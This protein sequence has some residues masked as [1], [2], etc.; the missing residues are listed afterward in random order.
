MFTDNT[1]LPV[2]SRCGGIEARRDAPAT[3]TPLSSASPNT[4]EVVHSLVHTAGTLENH[5]KSKRAAAVRWTSPLLN[6]AVMVNEAVVKPQVGKQCMKFPCETR[7]PPTT[8]P[9]TVVNALVDT[10]TT[11]AARDSPL[12]LESLLRESQ[13]QLS[14]LLWHKRRCR[15]LQAALDASVERQKVLENDLLES[16]A[17]SQNASEQ[18]RA[19]VAATAEELRLAKAGLQASEHALRV[20]EDEVGGLRRENERFRKLQQ[21]VEA[22]RTLWHRQHDG[23]EK[24]LTRLRG[25]K[26]WVEGELITFRARCAELEKLHAA[27][28]GTMDTSAVSHHKKKDG[29]T[30]DDYEEEEEAEDDGAKKDEVRAVTGLQQQELERR[31]VEMIAVKKS[32]ELFRQNVQ[33]MVA[34]T[35]KRLMALLERGAQLTSALAADGNQLQPLT[36]VQ[37]E[38]VPDSDAAPAALASLLQCLEQQWNGVEET[39]RSMHRESQERQKELQNRLDAMTDAHVVELQTMKSAT[40]EASDQIHRMELQY[41]QLLGAMKRQSRMVLAA[42]NTNVRKCKG[43]KTSHKEE[44]E[45]DNWNST[46]NSNIS[47]GDNSEGQSE[48]HMGRIVCEVDTLQPNEWHLDSKGCLTCKTIL[49]PSYE[50]AVYALVRR[51]H[52]ATRN[53]ARQLREA[54]S[55]RDTLA[56]LQEEKQR[57]SVVINEERVRHQA[58][59]R[60]LQTSL[61]SANETLSSLQTQLAA[62]TRTREVEQHALLRRVEAAERDVQAKLRQERQLHKQLREVHEKYEAAKQEAAARSDIIAELNTKLAAHQDAT[63]EEQF[64]LNTL[65]SRCGDLVR[66]TDV[67]ETQMQREVRNQDSLYELSRKLCSAVALLAMRLGTIAAERFALWRAYEAQEADS[68]AAIQVIQKFIKEEENREETMLDLH[69][70]DRVLHL[71]HGHSLYAIVTVVIACGRMRHLVPS[72][73]NKRCVVFAVNNEN[74]EHDRKQYSDQDFTGRAQPPSWRMLPSNNILRLVE[75]VPSVSAALRGQSGGRKMPFVQLPP[76][77][78]LLGAIAPHAR[79][80]TVGYEETYALEQALALAELDANVEVNHVYFGANLSPGLTAAGAGGPLRRRI[81]SRVT[82][83]D[84]HCRGTLAQTLHIVLGSMRD[85]FVDLRKRMRQQDIS[86]QLAEKEGHQ[87]RRIA[88]EREGVATGFAQKLREYERHVASSFIARDVYQQ[89]AGAPTCGS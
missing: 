11:A 75:S 84:T 31:Y 89:L 57:Q 73:S 63:R 82:P 76:L 85:T 83:H 35:W 53:A 72:R 6:T 64:D 20:M 69:E 3:Q 23:M 29:G 24:E 60:R 77:K 81:L 70:M 52:Q 30:A 27:T 18:H 79:S 13:Q 68:R 38:D 61:K 42:T 7:P 19:Y 41:M 86:I 87:L 5:E 4:M 10:A 50:R 47:L 59:V 28:E 40:Q 36:E 33:H 34:M 56:K 45:D 1:P 37:R 51:T 14:E 65:R 80:G 16:S 88:Q 49:E 62:T 25:E 46:N 39:A 15:T 17:E 2:L 54:R 26:E 44:G 58:T 48:E 43:V 12:S 21:Q 71:H 55:M 8:S 67:L 32:T 78:T 74:S 66:M 9:S 22:E